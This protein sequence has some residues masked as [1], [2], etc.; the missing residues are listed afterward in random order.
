MVTVTFRGAI[1]EINAVRTALI[2]WLGILSESFDFFDRF[3]TEQY[4]IFPI[5][6][7]MNFFGLAGFS[8]AVLFPERTLHLKG[9]FA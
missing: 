4:V 7:K 9:M 5:L 8:D 6:F 1:L 3:F 2:C